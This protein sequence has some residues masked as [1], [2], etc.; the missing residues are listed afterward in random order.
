MQATALTDGGYGKVVQGKMTNEG[1]PGILNVLSGTINKLAC[2]LLGPNFLPLVLRKHRCR[3]GSL[4]PNTFESFEN[5]CKCISSNPCLTSAII[6]VGLD[7]DGIV[8][9]SQ[10]VGK[11]CKNEVVCITLKLFGCF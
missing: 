2:R 7:V 4:A 8:D 5:F 11:C 6:S 3:K 1:V 10:R 9:F